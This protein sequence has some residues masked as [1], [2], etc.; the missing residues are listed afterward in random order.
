MCGPTFTSELTVETDGL[1]ERRS[2]IVPM[3]ELVPEKGVVEISDG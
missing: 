1:K 3:Q 2:G